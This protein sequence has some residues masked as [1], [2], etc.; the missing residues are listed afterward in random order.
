MSR[1][2]QPAPASVLSP[3]A[4]LAVELPFL[5]DPTCQAWVT[6]QS[7][8]LPRQPHMA[9]RA[10]GQG[11]TVAMGWSCDPFGSTKIHLKVSHTTCDEQ[12]ELREV[13]KLQAPSR[14]S[15]ASQQK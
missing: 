4:C 13:R 2:L 10:T 11:D 3:R 8:D 5:S 7:W 1:L 9:H 6:C 14:T 12:E 15:M